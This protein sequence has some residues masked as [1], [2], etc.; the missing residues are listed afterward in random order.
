M[1]PYGHN[2]TTERPPSYL[3]SA[4]PAEFYLWACCQALTHT[5]PC[6]LAF[7]G[8]GDKLYC[9]D[10]GS[11]AEVISYRTNLMNL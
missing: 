2:E 7:G 9:H 6:I 8:P 5:Y 10:K 1:T 3:S 4:E 11:V